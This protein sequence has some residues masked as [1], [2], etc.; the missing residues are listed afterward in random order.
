MKKSN[1]FRHW[2][3]SLHLS[4]E[5]SHLVSLSS[6]AKNHRGGGAKVDSPGLGKYVHR[7]TNK[8]IW[9]VLGKN[10]LPGAGR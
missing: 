1:Y 7:Q 2:V 5:Q 8:N 6:G 3:F 10:D 9:E 4:S